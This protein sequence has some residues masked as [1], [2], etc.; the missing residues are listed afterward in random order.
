M[1]QSLNRPAPNRTSVNRFKRKNSISQNAIITGTI[2][3]DYYNS[4]YDRRDSISASHLT[5]DLDHYANE[6]GIS[7]ETLHSVYSNNS[8]NSRLSFREINGSNG[9]SMT[10]QRS[11][12]QSIKVIAKP[13][14][15][16]TKS[17]F[18]I[19]KLVG[20]GALGTVFKCIKKEN[21]EIYAIKVYKKTDVVAAGQSKHIK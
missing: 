3:M 11:S 13:L 10:S 14:P 2:D 18:D 4:L 19:V 9:P 16:A 5:T 20:K 17:D 1:R 12:K 7:R 21:Q 6:M 8:W 15:H